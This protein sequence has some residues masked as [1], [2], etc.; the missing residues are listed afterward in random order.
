MPLKT[1]PIQSTIAFS[2]DA[3]PTAGVMP[4][5]PLIFSPP[6]QA[7]FLLRKSSS[8]I[9]AFVRFA[10]TRRSFSKANRARLD[11]RLG[12]FHPARLSLS[13]RQEPRL[14]TRNNTGPAPM[15]NET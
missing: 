13:R 11:L 8:A 10:V 9:Q 5:K 2:K 14:F 12:T 3:F 4:A 15:L 6:E 1:V 7:Q